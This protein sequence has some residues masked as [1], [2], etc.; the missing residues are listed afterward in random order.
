MLTTLFIWH[1]QNQYLIVFIFIRNSASDC[2][3]FKQSD[4]LFQIKHTWKRTNFIPW[5][6]EPAHIHCGSRD[7]IFI[8]VD[9][10]DFRY[11]L[12]SNITVF[13]KAHDMTCSHRQNFAKIALT[14]TVVSVSNS[15][16]KNIYAKKL[17]QSSQKQQREVQ[18]KKII[19]QKNF[20]TSSSFYVK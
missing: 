15:H 5:H 19:S 1:K 4:K 20:E 10:Q 8:V 14:Q 7:I 11:S 2:L 12:N 6:V 17:C 13:S 3:C 16:M 18:R 9:E